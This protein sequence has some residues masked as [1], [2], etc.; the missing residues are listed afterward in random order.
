MEMLEELCILESRR[1]N[2]G[3]ERLQVDEG[4]NAQNFIALENF[5]ILSA[6]TICG[7]T[8]HEIYDDSINI[9]CNMVA[10]GNQASISKS[11]QK[12]EFS[13]NIRKT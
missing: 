6:F 9:A 5:S 7:F 4:G 11:G 8:E 10:V 2:K 13:W 3:E 1:E 12:L